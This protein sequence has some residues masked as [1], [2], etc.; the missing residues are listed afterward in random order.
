MNPEN[1]KQ[2]SASMFESIIDSLFAHGDLEGGENS[3]FWVESINKL[4]PGKKAE[5]VELVN[6]LKE[7]DF[8]NY[9][10]IGDKEMI[11]M[12]KEI[13]RQITALVD[14]E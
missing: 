5:V 7:N 9:K 2:E 1:L 12:R 8:G 10:K 11:A 4:P 3:A 6:K 13:G 14:S